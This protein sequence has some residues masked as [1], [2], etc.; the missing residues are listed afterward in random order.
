VATKFGCKLEVLFP[1]LDGRHRLAE[2]KATPLSST[3]LIEP[4][5]CFSSCTWFEEV[6]DVVSVIYEYYFTSPLTRHTGALHSCWNMIRIEV[7]R[8]RRLLYSKVLSIQYHHL[9]FQMDPDSTLLLS[10]L[11]RPLFRRPNE[12]LIIR[13]PEVSIADFEPLAGQSLT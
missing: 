6:L 4:R 1:K 2:Q 3:K 13:F 10:Q 12:R 5:S 8:H 7:V 9:L 11:R